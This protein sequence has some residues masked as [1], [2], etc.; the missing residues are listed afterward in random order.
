[1]FEDLYELAHVADM[2]ALAEAF[3]A[4]HSS[5]EGAE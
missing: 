1:M 5:D 2:P 4:A 3:E